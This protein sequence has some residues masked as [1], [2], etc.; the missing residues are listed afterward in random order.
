LNTKMLMKL[1]HLK[2]IGF[3]LIP[4][5][6]LTYETIQI[7]VRRSYDVEITMTQVVNGFIVHHKGTF[8]VFQRRVS[9]QYT[10]VRLY[11]AGSHL[12]R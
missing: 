6:Y 7:C 12:Y 8:T 1:I 3:T 4:G 2:K 11:D 9:V 5:Y 10:I